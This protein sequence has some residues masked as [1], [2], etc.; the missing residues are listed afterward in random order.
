MKSKLRLYICI[1]VSFTT[2]PSLIS[3]Y[4]NLPENHVALFIFG[5][6][7]FD[8]GN[9]NYINT[10]FDFQ[11][12]FLPYGETFFKY[13]T[14]RF[15]DGRL[16]PDFIGKLALQNYTSSFNHKFMNTKTLTNFYFLFWLQLNLLGYQ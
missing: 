16:I 10:T 11:A 14:G 3:C 6:S 13:S 7:L 5:D 2:F 12:N 4:K 15:C 9:N 1:L 8:S